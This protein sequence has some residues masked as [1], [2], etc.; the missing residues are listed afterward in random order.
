MISYEEALNMVKNLSA[1][2]DL[3]VE[4]VD[5]LEAKGRVLAE[6]VFSEEVIP[7][8]DNS[9]MDGFA[10]KASET[11]LASKENPILL[12]VQSILA[13][14]DSAPASRYFEESCVEIMTGALLPSSQFDAVV[15]V[16]DVVRQGSAIILTAP[17]GIGCN[18][19][20]RGTD[21]EKGQRVLA[22]N[23]V[24]QEQHIMAL[25]ALGISRLTV[26]K[27]L[28]VAVLPTGNEIVPH[29][30]KH[31]Q[32]AQVR[33][34]SAPFLKVFLERNHC[35]V[36]LLGI[37][38]DDSGKF[39]QVLSELLR[40]KFDLVLT[41]GA[42]SMGKWDFI[43]PSLPDL[44]MKILFHKVAIRPG[45]PILLA[46]SED[47][48]TVFFGLPGNPISTAVGAQFFIK[49]WIERVLG[50]ETPEKWLA[51]KTDLK[52]PEGLECFF[53]AKIDYGMKPEVEVLKGQSSYMIHSFV[54]S[55]SWVQ[56]P[57]ADV[58]LSAGTAVRVHD[59]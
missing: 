58:F 45:K 27:K 12:K 18:V 22:K 1:R 38:G 51:L 23:V 59:L 57:A 14:G 17:I 41:T 33:N 53:K 55:N 43:A 2:F 28:R 56:L 10:V 6:D 5:L 46:Q 39:I 4:G 8:A 24:I 52:K 16:E 44:K 54:Q 36:T 48:R 42:V 11:F 31:V 9:A 20:P 37:L 30:Q 19:R 26:K 13:A 47:H 35:E 29:E 49:P 21:F 50:I 32:G 7:A 3:G 40:Q 25:A 15:K 34:S